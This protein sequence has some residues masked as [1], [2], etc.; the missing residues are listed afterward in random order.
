MSAD[1]RGAESGAGGAAGAHDAEILEAL[2]PHAGEDRI[3][4]R[5]A[6]AIAARL[7]VPPSQIGRVC[8]REG[9]KIANCQ[10]G[11]FGLR[12]KSR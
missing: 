7:G 3:D 11:C 8:N 2:R 12:G 9:I 10:L 4:C 6:L 1:E 5:D